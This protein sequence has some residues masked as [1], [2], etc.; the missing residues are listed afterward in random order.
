MD[1]YGSDAPDLRFK[2]ELIT[3][4]KIFENSEFNAFKNAAN[5]EEMIIKAIIL[6][7]HADE[8][9]KNA[10]KKIEKEVKGDKAKALATVSKQ[11]NELVSPILK[12][13]NDYEKEELSKLLTN[14]SI[15]FII[16]DEKSTTLTA[17]GNLRKRLAQKYK[18]Y[19]KNDFA[20]LWV[21]DFPAFEFDKDENRWVTPHHPFTDFDFESLKNGTPKNKIISRAYDIVLNG[22]EI[23]GGSIRIHNIEKQK[24]VF[25]L[26]NISQEEA[27]EKFGFLL[28][29]FS[30]GAPPHGGL[31]FGLDRLMMIL[32]ETE[33][34]RDVIAFPKTTSASCL[35]SQAPSEVAYAQLEELGIE[36]KK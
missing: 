9:S 30:F 35:M 15:A 19:S 10:I 33:A 34:I 2:M 1:K 32:L 21:I 31:A 23:G 26:L 11:N 7:N 24:E 17:L 4:D 3:L 22:H 28:E 25:N 8:F 5:N 12:F 13:L 20:P 16:A 29:A 36:I 27:Q 14:N 6:E 18:L